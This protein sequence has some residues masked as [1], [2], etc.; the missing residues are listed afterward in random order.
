MAVVFGLGFFL[1]GVGAAINRTVSG[2]N[3]NDFDTMYP[4]DWFTLA[5]FSFFIL[6]AILKVLK[7]FFQPHE[8]KEFKSVQG[9]SGREFRAEPVHTFLDTLSDWVY[10]IPVGLAGIALTVLSGNIKELDVIGS[11]LIW[12]ALALVCW[13]VLIR[14]QWK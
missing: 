8:E 10:I 9:I 13:K 14:R 2:F 6:A 7:D 4:G 1:I 5:G 3:P 11:F 12:M